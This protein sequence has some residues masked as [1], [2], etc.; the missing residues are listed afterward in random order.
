MCVFLLEKWSLKFHTKCENLTLAMMR[1]RRRRGRSEPP[2][3][4]KKTDEEAQ[5]RR[6]LERPLPSSSSSSPAVKKRRFWQNRRRMETREE[7]DQDPLFGREWSS[8]ENDGTNNGLVRVVSYNILCE[9]ATKK[10]ARELYPKQTRKDLQAETRI[11]KIFEDELQR[12]KPDVINLQ[13]VEAKRFK[14]I[15]KMMR[16][17]EGYFVKRGKGKTDGVATFFRKSKFATATW[18]KKPTRV[19][20]D[21]EDD[22]DAFGLVLVLENRK[23]RSV[24]VTGNAHVLFAPKNG[25][26]KLA[27]VKTILEAMESAK[28]KA[29][30]NSSSRVMKIFSLDGNF[31]PNSALYSFIEEGYFDKMSCNR[32]NMGGY[33]SEDTKKEK[34]CYDEEDE[35]EEALVG[36]SFNESNLRSW[37]DVDDGNTYEN[38]FNGSLITNLNTAS[39]RM[40]S[41]YKEVLK[42]EPSWT[43]CHRKFVGST[44]YIFFD[45]SAAKVMRVLKT[46]NARQWS[47]NLH[48][49]KTLPNRKYP[50]DHLSIV[51]DFSFK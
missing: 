13:E 36:G 6:T 46:P 3:L 31:L 41:A 21:D 1:G 15:S 48:E 25:L 12:L 18:S 40:R 28:R 51:A 37:N 27:Q 39:G 50:S 43:S 4:E 42:E 34:E 19:A 11:E 9:S 22:D 24:V 8:G 33:L 7:E 17:Y 14:Q 38:V 45:E 49:K 29:L 23:N 2:P 20:L 5:T 44:D 35:E 10:Y 32:R 30:S 47:N 16:K 26:V